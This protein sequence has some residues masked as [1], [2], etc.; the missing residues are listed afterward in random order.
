M[1]VSA[2][3]PVRP[4]PASEPTRRMVSR[5]SSVPTRGGVVSGGVEVVVVVGR[6]DGVAVVEVEAW[7][8]VVSVVVGAML[9]EVT[10]APVV[11]GEVE[12]SVDVGELAPGLSS[13]PRTKTVVRRSRDRYV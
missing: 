7:E 6:V 5:S 12:G 2:R 4:Y 9:V 1:M 11:L 3:D 13:P 10:G 8:T